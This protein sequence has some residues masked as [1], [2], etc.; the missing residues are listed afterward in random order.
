M[1]RV[2]GQRAMEPALRTLVICIDADT[3][4]SAPGSVTGLR[5][6]DLHRIVIDEIDSDAILHE[7]GDTLIDRGS[8]RCCLI[9][10]EAGDAA[11]AGLPDQQTLERFVC[12]AICA[13]YPQRAPCVQQWLD[14]RHDPPQPTVKDYAWS[15]MA[16]WHS[17]HGCDDFYRS[18]W[19]D[20]SVANEIRSRL[21]ATGAWRIA[22]MLADLATD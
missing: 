14:T 19:D 10:W 3:T 1:R 21:Q 11:A 20:E 7:S 18:L 17:E 8:T 5:V 12:S 6:A 4:V 16:G 13:V 9:R 22:E 15:Y 2:L